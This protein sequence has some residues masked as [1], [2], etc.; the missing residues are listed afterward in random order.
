MGYILTEEALR[1]KPEEGAREKESNGGGKKVSPG[2]LNQ[3]QNPQPP[4]DQ[5]QAHPKHAY[6]ARTASFAR[7]RYI[8]P[9]YFGREPQVK[10][11]DDCDDMVLAIIQLKY[12]T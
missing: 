8:E 9:C 6:H 2:Q 4:P 12:I 11:I 10:S 7:E 1:K 3:H 5:L